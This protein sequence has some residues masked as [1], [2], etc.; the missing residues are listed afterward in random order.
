[1]VALSAISTLG[2][3]PKSGSIPVTVDR[4]SI[5]ECERGIRVVT[6][7]NRGVIFVFP[8]SSYLAFQAYDAARSVPY[9]SNQMLTVSDS[10]LPEIP[11]SVRRLFTLE[12]R[13]ALESDGLQD[14]T[15]QIERVLMEA[16]RRDGVQVRTYRAPD[17]SL[18]EFLITGAT[19]D[20]LHVISGLSEGSEIATRAHLSHAFRALISSAQIDGVGTA[21]Q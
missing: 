18:K 1:M 14:F 20:L 5:Q 16:M 4:H 3:T 12:T 13:R 10:I 6:T 2:L 17:S 7:P 19:A 11:S 9:P 8:N 15:G 21:D